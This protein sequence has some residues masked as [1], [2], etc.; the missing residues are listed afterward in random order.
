CTS[1]HPSVYWKFEKA[2]RKFLKDKQKGHQATFSKVSFENVYPLFGQIDVKESSDARN[3]ATQKDLALQLSLIK[4]II[5]HLW[6]LEHLA[7]YEKLKFQLDNLTMELESNFKVDTE[8]QVMNFVKTDIEPLFEYQLTRQSV[9][10]HFIEDY[11]SKVDPKLN[12][13][14]YYRKNYDD[15][16]AL[17]NKKMAI[18]IDTKQIEAQQMY[19]HYFERYKTDGVEHNMYIGEA[20]TNE[21]NFNE[22]YL[23]N[24]R[25]WQLQVMCEME[26]EVYHSQSQFPISDRKS[27][28]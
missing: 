5:V 7:I 17:I 28:V 27:V 22:I 14:Y 6:E 18:V 1:I 9:T 13:I 19:P 23:Y 8:Q 11:V 25:L 2:A 24:L 20:I 3:L 4:K 10:S 15:T 26:N 12:I 16:I 21:G